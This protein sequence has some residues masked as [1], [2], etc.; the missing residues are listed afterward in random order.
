MNKI[1][2][3]KIR[4]YESNELDLENLDFTH[5]LYDVKFGAGSAN[6]NPVIIVAD[7]FLFVCK[8]RLYLFYEEKTLHNPGIIKMVYTDDLKIWSKPV[9]VLEETYHLSYPYVFEDNGKVYM[10]PETCAAKSIRVYE[11][12]DESLTHFTYK[13][14]LVKESANEK[15][16]TGSFCDS[17]IIKH[18]GS[19][20]LHTTIVKN[21][22]NTL[23]LYISKSL[24][25]PYELHL[26]NP[27]LAD[28]K[29]GRNGGSII[30]YNNNLYRIAQDCVNRYGD[31][32]HLFQIDELN[33]D[34]YKERLV[35]DYLYS[36]DS[37]FHHEGGHQLNICKFRDKYVIATDAKEYHKM[38]G[39]R[40]IYRLKSK[41]S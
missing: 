37:D 32:I 19:Y 15:D 2:C 10:I 5:P 6:G 14:T 3:F 29:Y 36:P 40:I 28:N 13:L 24:F 21:Q 18:N 26:N 20:Y 17:S 9:T 1:E 16:V 12:D 35:K 8:N 41:L 25:G 27:E 4:L 38:L 30:C 22:I 11:A 39:A 34:F 33:E 23:R 31:N 7:P